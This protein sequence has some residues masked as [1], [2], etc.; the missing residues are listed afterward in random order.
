MK[1]RPPTGGSPKAGR[2]RKG[3]GGSMPGMMDDLVR[4][5]G[6][7]VVGGMFALV[8]AI[9]MWAGG[10]VVVWAVKGV[11]VGPAEVSEGVVGV[12][13]FGRSVILVVAF[14]LGVGGD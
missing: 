13:R 6:R 9:V 12:A 5:C 2:I 1:T 14:V 8:A 10:A 3:K 7:V 4:G 11:I